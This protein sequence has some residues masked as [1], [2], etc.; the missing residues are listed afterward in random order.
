GTLLQHELPPRG[1]GPEAGPG[2]VLG[3][4]RPAATA[5]FTG[6]PAPEKDGPGARRPAT[7]PAEINPS[8]RRNDAPRSL[9]PPPAPRPHAHR[10]PG[11]AR[12]DRPGAVAAFRHPAGGGRL[13]G[14][15]ATAR[16]TGLGRVP[17]HPPPRAGRRGLVPGRLPRP[18][19]A[20][21]VHPP[22]RGAGELA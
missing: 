10:R 1:P 3:L 14:A 17:A 22:G 18:G 13:R 16:A 8:R 5:D 4:Y 12:A 15:A 6:P 21:G 2:T 19:P 9:P 7:I 20:G 11:R